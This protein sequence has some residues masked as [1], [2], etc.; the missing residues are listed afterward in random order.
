MNDEEQVRNI[1]K[2]IA[3]AWT[4]EGFKQRLLSHPTACLKAEGVEI[5]PGVEVRIV[6][7]TVNVHHLLLPLKPAST[8]LSEEQLEM[9]AGG[10]LTFGREKLKGT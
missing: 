6:E 5:P 3:K 7:D 4:D 2:V 10:G 9:V 1:H 8:P